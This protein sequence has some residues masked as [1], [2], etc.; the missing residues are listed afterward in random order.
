MVFCISMLLLV[1]SW[2][3]GMCMIVRLMLLCVKFGLLLSMIV[4][5]GVLG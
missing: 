4:C 5:S 2:C 1:C 3:V